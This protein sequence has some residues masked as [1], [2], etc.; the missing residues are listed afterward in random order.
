ML[1]SNLKFKEGVRVVKSLEIFVY[2]PIGEIVKKHDE[3]Q[4]EEINHQ[5]ENHYNSSEILNS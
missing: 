1:N 2:G 5:I 3:A 4:I